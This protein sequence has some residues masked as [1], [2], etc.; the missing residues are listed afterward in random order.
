MKTGM[1]FKTAFIQVRQFIQ[2][3]ILPGL[4][5]IEPE[6]LQEFSRVNLRRASLTSLLAMP[7]NIACVILFWLDRP[8]DPTAAAWRQA[9]II[10]HLCFLAA[11]LAVALLTNLLPWKKPG[12]A[13]RA[14]HLGMISFIMAGGLVVVTIDQMVGVNITAYILVCL[15]CGMLFLTP[16]LTA[17]IFYLLSYTAFYILMGIS[18]NDASQLLTA[19][20]NGLVAAA[21][22]LA[23]AMV[24]WRYSYLNSVQS[25][26]ISEQQI[27]LQTKNQELEKMAFLDPLTTLPNRRFFDEII[28]KEIAVI[29]RSSRV[30]C[31]LILDIDHFKTVNDLYGHSAGDIVLCQLAGILQASLRQSDVIARLGGEEFIIMLP[32]TQLAPTAQVADKLRQIIENHSFEI[33]G[34]K[35][36]LTASFGV[37]QLRLPQRSPFNYY[38][39][40]DKAL[41]QAKQKGRNRVEI[42]IP[43]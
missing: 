32:D 36:R 9:I 29:R 13:M 38:S 25:R 5:P 19:R 24:M 34:A 23:S 20:A 37:A 41:Y 30:S 26:Q 3:L 35:I 6:I 11:M 28:K 14:M 42:A 40:C 1:Q 8:V 27:L 17:F 10:S 7:V 31:L 21:I 16:P 39:E 18:Q 43:A 15:L 22:G 12:I 2:R 4:G 33:D